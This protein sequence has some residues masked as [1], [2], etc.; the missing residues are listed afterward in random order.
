MIPASEST[1]EICREGG[2]H[3]RGGSRRGTPF[4]TWSAWMV[5]TISVPYR[6]ATGGWLSSPGL[7]DTYSSRILVL[8]SLSWTL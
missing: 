2:P 5:F 1:V 4:L 7:L 6:L 8:G 3:W